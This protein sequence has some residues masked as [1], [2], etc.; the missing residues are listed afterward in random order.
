MQALPSQACGMHVMIV[1]L[2]AWIQP[3]WIQILIVYL[4]PYN[5]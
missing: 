5:S 3:E 4:H 2:P 1:C